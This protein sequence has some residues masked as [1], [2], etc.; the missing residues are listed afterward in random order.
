M[1]PESWPPAATR[2]AVSGT[3]HGR[4]RNG[5]FGGSTT[6]AW[7]TTL[8]TYA[9]EPDLIVHCAGSGSVAFSMTHPFQDYQRS[10][11]TTHAV[12]EYVRTTS[13]GTR[14]VLPSSAGIYGSV[15]HLPIGVNT[16]SKPA[17][18]YGHH[19]KMAEDLCRL[20]A[21][22]FGVACS[23]V[24][25]FSVY[26]TGLRKQ[27]LWD[28]CGKLTNGAAVFAGTGQETRDWLHVDDAATLILAAAE[29][30]SEQ[31][32]VANGGTGDET[33]I[34]SVVEML[35]A[36]LG[37]AGEF[38]FS[39][40]TRPGDPLHYRADTTEAEAWGWTPQADLS[41]EMRRYANW[42]KE[43]AI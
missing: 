42:F 20:Y 5:A 40:N 27:L 12:L 19:K 15:D 14:V 11:S 34:A 38:A 35:A 1:S 10:V 18:P 43:G 39:G 30:A 22:H 32:P 13:P 37:R 2:F 26:G 9:D 24:R 25:L 23:I 41:T 17:S 29:K 8:V 6:G 28:A 31:C 21:E 3:V 16:P 36:E 33:S 4:A 7:P